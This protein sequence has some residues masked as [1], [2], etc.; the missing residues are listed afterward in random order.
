MIEQRGAGKS[1][2]AAAAAAAP[3]A[4]SLAPKIDLEPAT[5]SSLSADGLATDL[6]V[7]ATI[8]DITDVK[9]TVTPEEFMAELIAIAK[10]NNIC[11]FTSLTSTKGSGGGGGDDNS[12]EGSNGSTNAKAPPPAVFYLASAAP[13][14]NLPFKVLFDP[15]P[16]SKAGQQLKK[17]PSNASS[18]SNNRWNMVRSAAFFI[19]HYNSV[20]NLNH[21]RK[22]PDESFVTAV[23]K[24]RY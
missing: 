19:T 3:V 5:N 22:G 7:A 17:S 16:S 15:N 18:L 4:N 12:S 11:L 9:N 20:T 1:D 6:E 8:P 13:P 14:A 24:F 10:S 2:D 23:R 21:T